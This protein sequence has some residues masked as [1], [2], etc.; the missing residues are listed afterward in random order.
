MGRGCWPAH[1]EGGA[2]VDRVG[3]GAGGGWQAKGRRSGVLFCPFYLGR[4]EAE[5]DAL[6]GHVARW[7]F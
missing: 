1:P 6:P 5:R 7:D 3:G 4:I 2:A